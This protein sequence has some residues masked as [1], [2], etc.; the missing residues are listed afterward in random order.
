MDDRDRDGTPE[1]PI[2]PTEPEST[3]E[4]H[5]LRDLFRAV[6]RKA[7]RGFRGIYHPDVEIHITDEVLSEFVHV[8]RIHK[9][10]DRRGRRLTDLAEMALE[11]RASS[12]S[13]LERDLELHQ[14][15]GDFAL[16]IAGLFPE[17][18]ERRAPRAASPLL[19]CVGS[20]VVA[21]DHPRDYYIVEG[22]SAYAHV[23]RVYEN[24]DPARTGL[25]DRLAK[26]FEEYL[27]VMGRIK[28]F[29]H[30]APAGGPASA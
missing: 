24:L 22:R 9:V 13:G 3:P 29:L 26:R 18:L 14:H 12:S 20:T 15:V 11:T 5:P 2:F 19:A 21:L 6:T 8:D 10:R 25:F 28:S 23:A 16:F 17:S 4:N 7:F 30:D 1:S 27:E